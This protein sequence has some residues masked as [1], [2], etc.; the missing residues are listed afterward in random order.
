MTLVTVPVVVRDRR[1]KAVGNLQEEDFQ[2]FDR[3]RQQTISKFAIEKADVSDTNPEGLPSAGG[4][5][6]G[7]KLWQPIASQFVA[8]VFDDLHLDA[9][10]LSVLRPAAEKHLT[11]LTPTVRAAIFTTSGVTMLDFTND[12]AKL[13]DALSRLRS[14]SRAGTKKTDCPYVSYYMA[15]LILNE[16]DPAALEAAMGEA[17]SCGTYNEANAEALV[18]MAAKIALGIGEVE[19][20][21]TVRT[22]KEIVRR[23]GAMPGHRAVVLPRASKEL[24]VTFR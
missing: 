10:N 8:Y 23:M 2:L 16:N 9:A 20:R 22:L 21:I 4:P 7:A 14:Q 13:H 3:G 24:M 12:R 19:T 5:E 11:G 18:R 1:G 6:S 17:I 15:D